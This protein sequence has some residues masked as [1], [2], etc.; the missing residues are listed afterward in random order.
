MCVRLHLYNVYWMRCMWRKTNNIHYTVRQNWSTS[1]SVF[2]KENV[3]FDIR[4]KVVPKK[5]RIE[6]STF[7]TFW[8]MRTIFMCEIRCRETKLAT[9]VWYKKMV[10]PH[11][12]TNTFFIKYFSHKNMRKLR[13]LWKYASCYFWWHIDFFI[14]T[15]SF[16]GHT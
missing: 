5:R 1:R 7:K 13:K 16:F 8:I 15:K 2:A 11:T 12:S 4:I 10:K 14:Q 3:W 6:T 9:Q